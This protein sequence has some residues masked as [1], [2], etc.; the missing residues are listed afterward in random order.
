MFNPT[1]PF[2]SGGIGSLFAALRSALRC[3]SGRLLRSRVASPI[4]QVLGIWK[5]SH[6]P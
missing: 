2:G 3:A 4:A 1:I 5:R 6:M